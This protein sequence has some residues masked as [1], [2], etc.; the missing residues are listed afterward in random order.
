MTLFTRKGRPENLRSEASRR[1]ANF[2]GSLH[3]MCSPD[4]LPW[5]GFPQ[6]LFPFFSCAKWLF[7]YFL[8]A[9]FFFHPWSVEKR[10]E[11]EREWEEC[12]RETRPKMDKTIEHLML[13]RI[14]KLLRLKLKIHLHNSKICNRVSASLEILMFTLASSVHCFSEIFLCNYNL[15]IIQ[16]SI[17]CD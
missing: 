10:W 11:S 13:E 4:S 14:W 17:E 5:K 6:K 9:F 16:F 1:F 12:K 8:C 15:L 2:D 3:K 7:D